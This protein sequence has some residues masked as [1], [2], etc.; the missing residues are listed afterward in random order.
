MAKTDYIN[1]L[2]QRIDALAPTEYPDVIRT[3]TLY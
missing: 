2:T 1:F 3:M